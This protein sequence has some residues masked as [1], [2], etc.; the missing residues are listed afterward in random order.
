MSDTPETDKLAK[1]WLGD[2]MAPWNL[3]R[4]LER[5][6][7]AARLELLADRARQMVECGWC[8]EI[9]HAPP[10]FEPPM[11]R[12]KLKQTV[13]L[14]LLDCPR[15]PIRETERDVAELE[16][17]KIRLTTQLAEAREAVRLADLRAVRAKKTL[18][19]S[20]ADPAIALAEAVQ[21][22]GYISA[23]L[24][25]DIQPMTRLF[26]IIPPEDIVRFDTRQISPEQ[27]EITM[28]PQ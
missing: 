11:T 12:E 14:H 19:V 23:R 22:A 25:M 17:D 16:S 1:A 5:E 27:W 21:T 3:A 9:M 13:R 18:T 7:D 15:H 4:K 26:Q 20:L 10:G 6:R 24:V 8:G 2:A 28:H